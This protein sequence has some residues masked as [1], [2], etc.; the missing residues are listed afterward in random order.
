MR[1]LT[2]EKFEDHLIEAKA[3]EGHVLLLIDDVAEQGW[4]AKSAQEL[5]A[6]VEEAFPELVQMYSLAV[7]EK[8]LGMSLSRDGTSARAVAL[9]LTTREKDPI[10]NFNFLLNAIYKEC[11]DHDHYLKIVTYQKQGG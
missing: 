8:V 5:W 4:H 11:T 10:T 6:V 2:K 9:Y 3:I 7:G 1:W